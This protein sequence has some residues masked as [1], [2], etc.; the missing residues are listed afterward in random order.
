MPHGRCGVKDCTNVGRLARG[1]CVACYAWSR[2]HGWADPK[3]RP[4]KQKAPADGQCTIVENG[5]KCVGAYHSDGMC[6]KHHSRMKRNGDPFTIRKLGNGGVRAILE[7]VA[8]AETD[9]CVIVKGRDRRWLVNT[10]DG[11]V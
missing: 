10:G 5:E 8:Q 9:E 7:A 3:G 6:S 2:S 1:W 11:W 4:R